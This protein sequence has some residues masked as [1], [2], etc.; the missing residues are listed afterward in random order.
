MM[1]A[2]FWCRAAFSLSGAQ[3]AAENWRVWKPALQFSYFVGVG[4][5]SVDL[6]FDY[7]TLGICGRRG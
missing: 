5:L 7:Q 6:T 2:F 3:S 4:D 1:N